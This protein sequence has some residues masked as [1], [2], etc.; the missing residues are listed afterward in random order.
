MAQHTSVAAPTVLPLDHAIQILA[1]LPPAAFAFAYGSAVV[2]QHHVDSSRRMIDLVLAVND[3]SSWHARNLRLNPSHYSFPMS[4]LGPSSI[5]ALQRSNFGARVYYNTILPSSHS[6][7]PPFK[8]GVVDLAHLTDDLLHWHSLYLSGRLHKPVHILT[9][10]PSPPGLSDAMATNLDAA[11]AAALLV[12]PSRF[13]E[14]TFYRTIASLSYRRDVRTLLPFEVA[15]KADDI[16]SAN[17]SAFRS[18]YARTTVMQPSSQL[19]HTHTTH[20]ERDISSNAQEQLLQMLPLSIR[21]R[22]TADIIADTDVHI[23]DE[24]SNHHSSVGPS[25]LAAVPHERLARAVGIAIGA[26]VLRSSVAQSLK[27]LATAGVTCSLRY[28]GAKFRKTISAG[29]R[30]SSKA[31]SSTTRRRTNP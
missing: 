16:V 14:H 13:D 15:S 23:H 10:P 1:Q 25:S 20:F 17:L 2:P 9:A 19:I 3:A 27:G 5:V 8:Y 11:T 26:V 22:V 24:G 30:R 4:N 28:I 18:L 6:T 12:L 31:I 21:K 7:H 29:L